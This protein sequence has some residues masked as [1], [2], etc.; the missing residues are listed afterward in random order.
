MRYNEEVKYH[1]LFV[2]DKIMGSNI[3]GAKRKKKKR[4]YGNESSVGCIKGLWS[5]NLT[6]I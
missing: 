4:F 6:A 2:N 1:Y 5:Y 3:L